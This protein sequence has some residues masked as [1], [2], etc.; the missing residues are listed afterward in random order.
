MKQLEDIRLDLDAVDRDMVRLF[1]KRMSLSGQVAAYKLAHGMPVLD[2]AREEQVLASR[3]AMLQDAR[4]APSLRALY[5]EIMRLSRQEQQRI[6]K[7]AESH[8]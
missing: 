2:T 4:L 5:V 3:A 8:A 6:L 1:E 7:E